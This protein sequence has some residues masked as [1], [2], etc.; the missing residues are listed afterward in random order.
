MNNYFLKCDISGIQSFIFNVPSDGAAQ[1]I[2]RRSLF[3]QNISKKCFEKCRQK[4]K[5]EPLYEGGGNFYVRIQSEPNEEKL[6]GFIAEIQKSYLRMDIFP[7]IAF[8]KDNRD[9]INELLLRVTH[10]MQKAKLRRPLIIGL[11]DPELPKLDDIDIR[12]LSNNINGQVPK[13]SR[14]SFLSF[15]D[16]AKGAEGDDK[17][18]ALKLDVDN[19]GQL[20][21]DLKE[22]DYKMLSDE[23]KDFFNEKLRQ[24]IVDRKITQN[25][26]VVFSGGDDCF[27]IGSWNVIFDLA[28]EIRDSFRKFQEGLKQKIQLPKNEVT[29]S[30]GIVVVPPKYPMIRLTEE[31]EEALDNSKRAESKNSISVF[32]K[33]IKWEEFKRS[34]EISKQL[35]ALI[36]DK[37]ESRSLIERIKSS[38]IGFDKL[39]QKAQDGYINIP[40]VWR[41]KY[42]LRNVKKDNKS[43]IE[44]LFENYSRAIIKTF[45]GE[46]KINPNLYPVAA[47][48]AE[49]LL[50]NDN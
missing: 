18:A 32:G 24:L 40:K 25:I 50:K 31:V 12:S 48:W 21:R 27:L 49:L 20:F 3:V 9:N 29:F 17:I 4:F 35:K 2:K 8:T 41:L 6:Q 7:Y 26:Y 47:R 14:G 43:E 30:A 33:T 44:E 5:V 36:K 1:E 28:I 34:Q 39:Q 37:G 45:L 13:D 16:I 46:E 19:L 11:L 38:T 23:L 42:Y 10:E 15:D 22:E